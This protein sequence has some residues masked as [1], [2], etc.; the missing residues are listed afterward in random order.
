MTS[1][2]SD[3]GEFRRGWPIVLAS[4]V[5]IALGLS[6]IPFYEIG[7]FAP[8]LAKQFGWGIGTIMAAC[9]T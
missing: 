3:S 7:L 4:G 1:H 8:E 5:G 6:P 9:S 2:P